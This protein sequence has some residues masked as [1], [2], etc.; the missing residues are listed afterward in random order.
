EEQEILALHVEDEGL[1]GRPPRAQRL[2]LEEPVEQE[3]G[4]GGL[5]RDARDAAD[6]HVSPSRPI[7]ELEVPVDRPPRT[8]EADREAEVLV[9]VA[10]AVEEQRLLARLA[11]CEV[12]PLPGHWRDVDL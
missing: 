5:R 8:V 10:H 4:V 2:A 6:V 3:R 12:D 11:G 9:L 1:R 7:E